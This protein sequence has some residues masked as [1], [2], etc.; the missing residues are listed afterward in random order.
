M[1]ELSKTSEVSKKSE[2]SKKPE[3]SKKSVPPETSTP[4]LKQITPPQ[5]ELLADSLN[6]NEPAF[7]SGRFLKSLTRLPGIYQM[8]NQGGEIIYIGKAKNLK[9]RVSS[10][11]QKQDHPPKTRVMV[12][13]ISDIQIIVTDSENEALILEN[14]LIKKYRPR[15]NVVFRD[16]KSYPYIFLSD[17]TYPRLTIHRGRHKSKGDYFGPFTGST[18]ARYSISLMQR[19]FRIRQCENSVFKHRSRPCLQY[20]IN[21]CSGSCVN[22][23]SEQD[24]ISDVQLVRL[25]YQGKN[26]SVIET[27]NQRMLGAS[28]ALDY[29]QAARLRDQIVQLRRVLEQQIV[30]GSDTDTDIV[31]VGIS[32]KI[33]AVFVLHIRNGLV[34]GNRNFYPKVPGG[35]NEQELLESF[36]GHFY[37]ASQN[38]LPAEIV[39]N[40]Q[41][42]EEK[43]LATLLSE[44]RQSKVRVIHR[45]KTSR[46]AWLKMANKNLKELISSKLAS[47]NHTQK[48]MQSLMNELGLDKL[49]ERMECFD[50]SHFQGEQTVASCVVF[51]GG[52]AKKSDYRR[53]NITG[54]IEGDD[55]AAIEQAVRRRFQRLVKED[56]RLPDLLI[57]DG[58]KGQLHQAQKVL[59]SLCLQQVTL[60]SVAKGSDRK[61]G[62]EQ[63]F[64]PSEAVARRLE[65]DSPGLHLIQAIRDEAHRF[66][67]TGHRGKRDKVR[68]TSVL[69]GIPG[70]GAKR[71]RAIIQHFGG[72]Q[73][74]KRAGVNDLK[75]VE[76]ISQ[77]L[78]QLIYDHLH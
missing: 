21:R 13:Q 76:G 2:T 54:V 38:E 78:A 69:E 11:F 28:A 51:E 65:E 55:Y 47:Q 49:P 10:Y 6:K 56:A 26:E 3:T 9:N 60:I 67:I 17:E 35:T 66:A 74:I 22:K 70:V 53:F 62:M 19:L 61:V 30:R 14:Q 45:V 18:A 29:E 41:L 43:E 24:Y 57:I 34:Q 33:A 58:G 7:D 42:S 23:I 48:R 59:E 63:I 68:K 16:D 12:S 75:Q 39:V 8:I 27:L 40:H 15:Y 36:I 1:S 37:T 46:A 20:Q 4:E 73:E 50:I 32:E 64:F 71:R 5:Q 52:A 72:L 31:A 44:V 25:F 77:N